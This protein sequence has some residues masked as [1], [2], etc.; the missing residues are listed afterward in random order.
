MP[1]ADESTPGVSGPSWTALSIMPAAG[2]LDKDSTRATADAGARASPRLQRR[3]NPSP[4]AGRPREVLQ[5][6]RVENLLLI[7][8][9]E[10]RLGGG[11]NVLT[12]ETGAGKTVLAH[13]LDLLMGGRARPGIVRPG[14]GGG[15]GRGDLRSARG[16][17]SSSRERLSLD[18]RGGGARP[19]GRRDGRTRAYLAGRAATAAELE[20][21]G[22]HAA[23]V[24]RPAR[25][26]Q[27]DGLGRRWRSSTAS[28][29][30]DHEAR[31]RGCAE[32][33]ARRAPE[34]R[35]LSE[36][37]ER[38]TRERELDLS[39]TSSPRSRGRTGREETSSVRRH[40]SVCA[41]ARRCARRRA[42]HADALAPPTS[43]RRR[44][45]A[46]AERSRR[47]TRSPA[48]TR[49]WTRSPSGSRRC[50]ELGD[51]A[52]ELRDY[53]ERGSPAR[54]DARCG[55]LG[56]R[57][58]W[59]RSTD[60]TQARRQRRVGARP[61]Q[62]CRAESHGWTAPRSAA[63][64]APTRSQRG[65]RRARRHG[66]SCA[67]GARPP[68]AACEA[69]SPTSS[70]SWRWAGAARGRP[71]SSRPGPSG[72][73]AVEFRVAPNPGIGRPAARDRLR[74]RALA[75]DAGDHERRRR[76]AAAATL[77]FDEIDAGIGGNTARV[78]GERLR[79]LGSE[80]QVLCI[81]HLPQIASL[82]AR[83]FPLVKDVVAE[84]TRATA[85]SRQGRGRGREILRMLGADT[86]EARPAV[87]P[88]SSCAPPDSPDCCLG[89]SRVTR[90]VA[91]RGLNRVAN[92]S[93]VQPPSRI[94]ARS[95]RA[96]GA[97]TRPVPVVGPARPGGRTKLSSNA[98]SRGDIAVIDHVN[99][100]RVSAEELIAAASRGAQRRAVL[101][102]QVPQPRAAD[103]G[104]AGILLVDP[105]DDRCSTRLRRDPRRSRGS[106]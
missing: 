90:A 15:L 49:G 31:L 92:L 27:A 78:V 88:A 52:A 61:R 86:D 104:R 67:A 105:P 85:S 45:P 97:R 75:R 91:A 42:P 6:L 106:R 43:K 98:S 47:W 60:S 4:R 71:R 64:E 72:G 19:S 80:H 36:L 23:R 24:L 18:G 26:P 9:A 93:A 100:D 70:P 87:T 51:V 96:R 40:A 8:E 21:L 84:P 5:E 28:A 89:R 81:T 35:R 94:G 95:A 10:L 65:A 62:R 29:A 7:E 50:V 30:G 41:T 12:G 99:I 38:A 63:R 14:A 76:P 11:L 3:R 102:W 68:P 39:G 59:T 17:A 83:H 33:T 37:R 46:L 69:R 74:R 13:S 73:D 48:S 103:A 55:V 1:V 66:L 2:C 57:S 58:G 56:S 53:A 44:R 16:C 32:A 22:G 101:R 34:A 54:T 20:T 79:A 77:V 82:A 25:A